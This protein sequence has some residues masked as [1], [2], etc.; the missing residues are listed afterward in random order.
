MANV[1]ELIARHGVNA[2]RTLV[3]AGERRL[4]DVAAQALANE[5]R[6]LGITY[7]GFCL[8]SLPHNALPDD[9]V[10]RRTGHKVRLIIEP[11]RLPTPG[12][13]DRLYGVPYGSRARLI[14]I[15]LQTRAIQTGSPDVE[16]G[17]SM[18]DWL[19]RMGVS[20]GGKQYKDVREQAARIS[21]C[22]LT[23]VWDD[24]GRRAQFAKDT[25]VKGGIQ[26]YDAEEDQPRLWV[27]TVRL[28]DSFF[29]A[30]REHPVPVWEPA[31]KLIA[32]KSLAIDIYVWLAYRLHVLERATPITWAALYQQ[33]G[34]SYATMKHF[35]PR[36]VEALKMALAVY[37]DARLG[38]GESGIVMHPSLPPIP[39]RRMVAS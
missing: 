22:H 38:V 28:S 8:T 14:L 12:G 7:A 6:A 27:D 32:N 25:I 35:K 9:E 21:A 3:S 23:F 18:R 4:V 15:Y 26:L 11:G 10:W 36:F 13:G 24:D 34:F 19:G 5:S 37:P 30:L 31:M 29:K 1:H 17:S 2:A 33:F 16:L 39:E 20:V